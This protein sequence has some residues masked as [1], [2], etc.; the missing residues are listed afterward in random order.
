MLQQSG[1]GENTSDTETDDDS[2][3]RLI[4]KFKLTAAEQR[5][6]GKLAADLK[7]I[8]PKMKSLAGLTHDPSYHDDADPKR[9][10]YIVEH[11]VAYAVRPIL[12][13]IRRDTAL[14]NKP[15][16]G[17]YIVNGRH[18]TEALIQKGLTEGPV[19]EVEGLTV[20]QEAAL[21]LV[22]QDQK[23]NKKLSKKA[24][25]P[26]QVAAGERDATALNAILKRQGFAINS[27]QGKFPVQGL[28]KYIA[29]F[30]LDRGASLERAMCRCKTA[31]PP[32]PKV[33][34]S[35]PGNHVLAVAAICNVA[36]GKIDDDVLTTTL[37]KFTPKQ[38]TAA[39]I[40]KHGSVN[41]RA[42]PFYLAELICSVYSH[43][44]QKRLDQAWVT[45][46]LTEILPRP[47]APGDKPKG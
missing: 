47:K 1:R 41:K 37:S 31:W 21:Y 39:V 10:K 3:Y 11:Y 23:G 6:A 38:W 34:V 20:R 19:V 27:T 36:G 12:V 9:V 26:A 5:E 46:G 13:S 25:F 18:T 8:L 2:D 16:S 32:L 35:I 28:D 30:D 40:E 17:R 22:I 45:D 44:K 14:F 24:S 15:I 33:R 43:G 4:G 29:A 42:M 7:D